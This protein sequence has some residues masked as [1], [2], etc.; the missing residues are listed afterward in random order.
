MAFAALPEHS[1]VLMRRGDAAVDELVKSGRLR[2]VRVI[3]EIADP[4]EFVVL[5]R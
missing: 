4:P 5:E 2:T 1:L 3:P